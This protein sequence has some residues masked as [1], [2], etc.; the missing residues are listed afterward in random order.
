MK[1]RK[2]VFLI[3][4]VLLTSCATLKSWISPIAAYDQK[5]YESLT[6]LK[7][8]TN[9]MIDECVPDISLEK[10]NQY[11]LSIDIIYE[12]ELGKGSANAEVQQQIQLFR[13][14]MLI[15][16]GE[17]RAKVLSPVYKESKKETLTRILD[18]I[19]ATEFQKPR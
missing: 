7:A 18:V 5:T 6:T 3:A 1:F 9:Q 10:V 8:T 13:D 14:R 2:Y 15:F 17:A 19:I 16:L 11:I 12:Y 4:L